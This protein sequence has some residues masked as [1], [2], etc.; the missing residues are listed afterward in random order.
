M[1][2]RFSDEVLLTAFNDA[3]YA[4]A[5]SNQLL[6]GPSKV[7]AAICAAMRA[8][9][10]GHPVAVCAWSVDE[11][12]DGIWTTSC[13]KDF[14]FTDD[15]PTENNFWFCHNCGK[16]LAITPPAQRQDYPM[17]L[18]C[19]CCGDTAATCD[20]DGLFYDGQPLECGC[21]GHVSVDEEEAHIY[22][23]D[24]PCPPHAKCHKPTK[25]AASDGSPR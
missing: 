6:C 24:G 4:A 21:L 11:Y 17:A 19:H 2:E 16:R 25:G 13:G 3:E 14:V 10:E 23:L 12:G 9:L 18:E 1:S 20:S 8:V 5:K 15:G 22:I 7:D